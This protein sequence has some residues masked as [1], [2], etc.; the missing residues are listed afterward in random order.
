MYLFSPC[1]YPYQVMLLIVVAL[2]PSREQRVRRIAQTV[3]LRGPLASFVCHS[4]YSLS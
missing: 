2:D 4:L 1:V 3:S